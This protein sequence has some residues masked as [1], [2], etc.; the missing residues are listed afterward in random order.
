MY[1]YRH[2]A[3]CIC[4]LSILFLVIVFQGLVRSCSHPVVIEAVSSQDSNNDSR[5]ILHVGHCVV[6]LHACTCTVKRF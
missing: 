6:C 1:I 2:N 4:S 5:L 3:C